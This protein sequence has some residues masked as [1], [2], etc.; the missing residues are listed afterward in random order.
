MRF[1]NAPK[2]LQIFILSNFG[3]N[4]QLQILNIFEFY[5]K[6]IGIEEERIFTIFALHMRE[7]SDSSTP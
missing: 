5:R 7:K 6:I 3:R 4:F 1:V 2:Q